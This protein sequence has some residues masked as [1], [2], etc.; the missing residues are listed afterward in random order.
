MDYSSELQAAVGNLSAPAQ[1]YF[2][3]LI[4]GADENPFQS[5]KDINEGVAS[6]GDIEPEYHTAAA[7]ART[8]IRAVIDGKPEVVDLNDQTVALK[9]IR[10]KIV[11]AEAVGDEAQAELYKAGLVK[12][13][14]KEEKA[15]ERAAKAAV[16]LEKLKATHQDAKVARYIEAFA[17]AKDSAI[18]LLRDARMD[19]E[20]AEEHF[21]KYRESALTESIQRTYA[22]T[23]AEI[24]AYELEH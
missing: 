16:Q 11:E 8:A 1:Q 14:D 4:N 6:G 13:A 3:V 21:T 15:A 17:D 10:G 20:S 7:L 9:L 24:D 23:R 12:L 2:S 18:Q 22:V 19:R 5:I